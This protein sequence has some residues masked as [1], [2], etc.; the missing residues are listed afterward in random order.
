MA[1][2]SRTIVSGTGR[3]HG[4]STLHVFSLG[5]PPHE[6]GSMITGLWDEVDA[7]KEGHELSRE[8]ELAAYAPTGGSKMFGLVSVS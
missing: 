5:I 3:R 1:C 8:W 6:G 4:K 2:R 7:A